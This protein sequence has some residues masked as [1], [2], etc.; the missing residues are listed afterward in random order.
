MDWTEWFSHM[1]GEHP[2]CPEYLGLTIAEVT[3]HLAPHELRVIDADR[4]ES[5]EGRTYLTAERRA[6]R[7]NVLVQDGIVTSAAKF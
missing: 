4:I 2:R 7:V 1:A 6:D 5:S 3:E